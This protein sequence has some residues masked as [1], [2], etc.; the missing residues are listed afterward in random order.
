M[1]LKDFHSNIFVAV[2]FC[3]LT[4]FGKVKKKMEYVLQQ[5]S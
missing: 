5:K 4:A 2:K 1:K 3:T